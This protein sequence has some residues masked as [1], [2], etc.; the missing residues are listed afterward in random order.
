MNRKLLENYGYVVSVDYLPPHA[1]VAKFP[2]RLIRPF[3]PALQIEY[4]I[5][6]NG[7]KFRFNNNIETDL[8]LP[9]HA[10]IPYI[11]FHIVKECH[12]RRYDNQMIAQY[13]NGVT[14]DENASENDNIVSDFLWEDATEKDFMIIMAIMGAGPTMVCDEVEE[15]QAILEKLMT[16]GNINEIS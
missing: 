13:K 16:E 9:R 8:E 12:R 11:W 7:L 10:I 1:V 14:Y 5:Q 6:D 2:E 4:I 15:G 3:Y